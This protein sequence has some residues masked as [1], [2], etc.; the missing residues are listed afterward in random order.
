MAF[1]PSLTIKPHSSPITTVNER[2]YNMTTRRLGAYDI[3][4]H[5]HSYGIAGVFLS[6]LVT[7]SLISHKSDI[8]ERYG[9]ICLHDINNV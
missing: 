7:L 6:A 4:R 5:V 1:L 8:A 3:P 9:G 2:V